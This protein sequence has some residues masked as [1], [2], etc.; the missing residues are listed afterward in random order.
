MTILMAACACASAAQESPKTPAAAA[1]QQVI[2]GA[3]EAML[4]V[5][6]RDKRGTVPVNT[7]L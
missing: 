4:D 2:R 6:V 3:Q 5:V 1:P 7:N